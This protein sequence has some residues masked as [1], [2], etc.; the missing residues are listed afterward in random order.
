MTRLWQAGIAIIVTLNAYDLPT[1]I[2][3][4]KTL[5]PVTHIALVW[6]VDTN[7]WRSHIYR[8]YYRLR[9]GE[10]ILVVIYHD[11]ITDTWALERCYD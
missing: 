3:W 4:H 8:D 10:G 7:W 11:L 2:R 1:T 9:I 6:Q 5:Y